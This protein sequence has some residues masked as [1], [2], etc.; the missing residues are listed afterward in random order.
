MNEELEN[1]K[2]NQDQYLDTSI[3]ENNQIAN[4][5]IDN[6]YLAAPEQ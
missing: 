2:D 4:I 3:P 1:Q 5:P 6:H